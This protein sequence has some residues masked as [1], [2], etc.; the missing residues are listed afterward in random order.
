MTTVALAGCT[1]APS[2]PGLEPG[3]CLAE[4][5]RDD[6]DRT[7]LVP[8]TEE[9]IFDVVSVVTWPEMEDRIAASSAVEVFDDIQSSIDTEL[10]NAYWAWAYDECDVALRTAIGMDGVAIGGIT[11]DAM[12]MKPSDHLLVD[13]SLASS[14][15]FEAGEITTVCSARWGD[16]DNEEVAL[17][18]PAGITVLDLMSSDFPIDFR[19]CFVRPDEGQYTRVACD[20]PHSGEYLVYFDGVESIGAEYLETFSPETLLFNDYAPLDESCTILLDAVYPGGL[21]TDEWIVWSDAID[22][23]QGW[24]DYAGVVDESLTYPIYCGIYA[25]NCGAMTGDVIALPGG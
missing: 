15:A 4:Y 21:D 13:P 7:S 11:S 20:D 22:N 9:H 6:S 17:T 8:C 5:N 3:A 10:N 23:A 1:G 24:V 14:E 19:A 2:A 16:V 12:N 25:G 18:Y